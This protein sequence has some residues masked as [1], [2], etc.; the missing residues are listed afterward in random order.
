MILKSV[1]HLQLMQREE[2]T[3]EQLNM[4]S[5]LGN[6]QISRGAANQAAHSGPLL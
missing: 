2:F 6:N 1:Q 4:H 5:G 3:V